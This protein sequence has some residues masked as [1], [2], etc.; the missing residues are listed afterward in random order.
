MVSDESTV[1]LDKYVEAMIYDASIKYQSPR[2]RHYPE[3][4]AFIAG[5]KY[6]YLLACQEFGKAMNEKKQTGEQK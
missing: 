1:R 4:S 2:E 6:G 3:R 5:A